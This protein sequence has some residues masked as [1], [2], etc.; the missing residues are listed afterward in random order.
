MKLDR[1]KLLGLASLPDAE[2]WR[3]VVMI[4]KGHGFTLPDKA[5]PH[6]ELEKLREIIKDGSKINVM[7][8]FKLLNKY[9]GR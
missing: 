3:T 6:E 9:K 4:G 8:A 1:E 5:P 2:L 7:S